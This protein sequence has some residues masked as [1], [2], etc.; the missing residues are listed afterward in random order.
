MSLVLLH[1][2]FYK[3]YNY[4]ICMYDVPP[5]VPYG[6]ACKPDVGAA[7]D[8]CLPP[9]HPPDPSSRIVEARGVVEMAILKTDVSSVICFSEMMAGN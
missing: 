7:H 8:V 6:I 3:C 2:S 5:H 1:L 4:L 9:L